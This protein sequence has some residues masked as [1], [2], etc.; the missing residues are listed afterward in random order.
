MVT[1]ITAM[2]KM[3]TII[4]A[5]IKMVTITKVSINSV[6]KKAIIQKVTGCLKRQ[7]TTKMDT[8]N[9]IGILMTNIGTGTIKT[10]GTIT[11]N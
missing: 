6:T 8:T 3:V 9:P 7:G 5:I 11:I 10:V 4:T 2:I 1:I